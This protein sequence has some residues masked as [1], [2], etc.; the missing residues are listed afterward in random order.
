MIDKGFWCDK[1]VLITGHTGFKGSWLC[2]TLSM[3]KANVVGY[4]LVP[5]DKSNLFEIGGVEK[6]SKNIFADIRN[7]ELLKNAINENKPEIV[8]HL[9]AQPIVRESYNKPEYT[10]DVNVMGT[11]NILEAIRQSESVRSFVNVTTDKVYLNNE[12][13]WG[14]RETDTLDGYDPYA[15]SKSCSE[16]VTASYKRS[17][18]QNISVSTCRAGNVIGGGDFAADRIIPDCIKASSVNS[19]IIIRNP[20]AIRPY[21]FV[22]EPIFA[23]LLIAQEQYKSPEKYQ[24]TYNIG[25]NTDDCVT[26]EVL[27]RMFC[28]I[29]GSNARWEYSQDLV[30]QP[31]ESNVLRLDCSKLRN[32][33]SWQPKYDIYAALQKTV[34]WFKAYS[35]NNNVITVMENQISEFITGRS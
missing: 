24:G 4:S 14:Y 34:E 3:L 35:S 1:T 21:Q 11:V 16:L 29:W 23:Y 33:F 8:F 9:A 5:L 26:T 6:F 10:Y 32:I 25:P 20:N 28:D 13:F 31:H 30:K 27:V 7:L 12:S 18:L 15:N 19:P 22:L 2:K 17:F